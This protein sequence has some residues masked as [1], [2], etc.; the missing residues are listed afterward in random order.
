MP[1]RLEHDPIGLMIDC[2]NALYPE[3]GAVIQWVADAGAGVGCAVWPDDGSPPYIA[4]EIG[5]ALLDAVEVLAHEV[6]H[7]V[8]GT[9]EEDEHGP[10]WESAFDAL[11]REYHRR[12]IELAQ[13]AGVEL[14]EPA[15]VDEHPRRILAERGITTAHIIERIAHEIVESN[16]AK[17]SEKD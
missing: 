7:I 10:Q 6:A 11:H 1:F 3:H 15:E 2:A 17:C 16:G 14:H 13:A 4:L 9:D 5:L 12:M 8:V